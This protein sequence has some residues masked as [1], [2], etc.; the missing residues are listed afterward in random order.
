MDLMVGRNT[1]ITGR[2]R[3]NCRM[4]AELDW[5]AGYLRRYGDVQE[6]NA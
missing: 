4:A 5:R 3:A 1:D 6:S 2:L